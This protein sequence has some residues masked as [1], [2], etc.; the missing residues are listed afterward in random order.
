MK[1]KQ[2]LVVVPGLLCSSQLWQAQTDALADIADP[3][4]LD[5]TRDDCLADMVGRFLENAPS[6]FALAGLSMGGYIAFEIFRQ[7]PERV[8]RLALLDTSARP[9][10]EA[11]T[12][13][14]RELVALARES[15]L[16]A[17]VEHH[18]PGFLR[19]PLFQESSWRERIF[20]MAETIGVDVYARQQA[21]IMQRPDSRPLL[22]AIEVPTLVI[23]GAEDILTPPDLHQEITDGIPGARLEV[24]EQCGHLSTM[25]QPR[26]VN[27]L[28]RGWLE[29]V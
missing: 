22:P 1:H 14:R 10:S 12:L 11:Q 21:A 24:I 25:E 3:V 20:S 16:R 29:Q 2:N 17:A 13:M 23:C 26:A 18:L 4:L 27:D 9:D 28:L 19:A 6:R 15:G 8:T 5:T 7:A